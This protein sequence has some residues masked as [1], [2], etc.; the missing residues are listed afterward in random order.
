[1]TK[2]ERRP[3]VPP[4]DGQLDA[5]ELALVAALA[6]IIADQIREEAAR[7]RQGAAVPGPTPADGVSAR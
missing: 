3:Y 5:V 2:A 4:T 7:D 1:V 6:D